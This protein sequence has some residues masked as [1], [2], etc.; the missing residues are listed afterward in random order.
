MSEGE[1]AATRWVREVNR[2]GFELAL[3][4][5]ALA[6]LPAASLAWDAWHAQLGANP[7]ERIQRDSGRWA[8]I[9]L[10]VVLSATPL[11]HALAFAARATGRHFGRRLSDWNW[12]IRLR[13]PMGLACFAYALAHVAVY[14]AL[15]VGFSAREALRDLNEKPFI[16]VGLAT[17]LL[18]VPLALTST[19]GWMRRLKRDWKR[20]HGLVYPAAILAVLH[21]IW[22]SKPGIVEAYVHAGLLCVLLG[23]RIAARWTPTQEPVEALGE[24]VLTRKERS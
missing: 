19:E 1:P 8:L 24:E 22:L 5:C 9:L 11:R 12:M 3:V 10:L 23:Y 6:A 17:F 18:L 2:H 7:L 15:D 13:R 14:V 20:L 16:A 4:A 21:F